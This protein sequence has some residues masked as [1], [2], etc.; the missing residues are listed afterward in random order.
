[1]H[2]DNVGDIDNHDNQHRDV[3]GAHDSAIG[4]ADVVS[5]AGALGYANSRSNFFTY[6][7]ADCS[8]IRVS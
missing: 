7:S 4:R 5:D 8:T 2:H 6:S 1:M 3:G